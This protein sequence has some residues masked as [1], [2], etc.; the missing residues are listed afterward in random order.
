MDNKPEVNEVQSSTTAAVDRYLSTWKGKI[1]TAALVATNAGQVI[2]G[3]VAGVSLLS[4]DI[5]TA[6]VAGAIAAGQR[7]AA[8]DISG[9]ISSQIA[10][11][12]NQG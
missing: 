2:F 10:K 4:G 8:K 3:A 12:R 6:A 7:G 9:N 1:D 5:I 11:I